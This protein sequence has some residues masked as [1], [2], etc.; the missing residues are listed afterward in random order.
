MTT[1]R[2]SKTPEYQAWHHAKKRCNDPNCRDFLEYGAKGIKMHKPWEKDFAAFF[3]EMG[4]RPTKDHRVDRMDGSKGYEPG[5]VQWA[6]KEQQAQNRPEFVRQLTH[7]GKTMTVAEWSRQLGMVAT[8]IYG[9]LNRGMSAEQALNQAVMPGGKNHRMLTFKG[10]TQPLKRW[11][12]EVGMCAT[13]VRE[14][15]KLGWTV[16]RQ[17]T[18]P[19]RLSPKANVPA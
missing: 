3:L 7:N 11:A 17:L 10:K 18:Q 5:N 9:R 6:T 2:M 1:H 4:L 14:R 19:S 13:T 16:E 12:R 15:L 8:T